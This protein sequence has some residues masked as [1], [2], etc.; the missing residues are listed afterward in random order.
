VRSGN[1]RPERSE[2][3]LPTDQR[4]AVRRP[5]IRAAAAL[6]IASMLALTGC[7]GTTIDNIAVGPGKGWPSAFHDARNSATSTVTGSRHLTASWARPIGG[8]VDA[9]TTVGPDGQL[10]VTTRADVDCVGKPGTTGL[11]FSFQMATGRKRFCYPLGPD[12][13]GAASAV[14]GATNVYVGDNGG[15]YSFNEQGQPRWRTPVAGIPV[16]VQFTGDSRVLSVTQLGQVDVLD[17][18]TGDRAVPTFQVLGDPDFLK[19]PDV[20]RPP[21][22]Q[23]IG[24]CAT[25]GSQCPVANVSAVDQASGRCYVTVWR[26]GSPAASLVALRYADHTIRQEWSADMLTDGSATSPALSADGKTVYVGDNSG[27]LIAV[28]TA[29]GHTKWTQP[30]GF[31]PRGAV[32]VNGD[33][34][35]PGGDEG[36]LL[37]LRDKGDSVEVA[38]ERK[39]LQLRGRPV[40]TAG[41]TGYVVAPIGDALNLVTFD[42]RTGTTVASAELPGVQG[43]TIGTAVGDRGEVVVT[44]RLGELFAFKPER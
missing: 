10:F 20:P 19:S 7:G 36:H 34:L 21:D 26:P 38:W 4:T 28:D 3:D 14:D 16:S 30:L 23:G 43:P 37:A 8:L 44:A 18:Q 15:M 35:I 39:D 13:A 1:R 11:I 9:A 29:D 2:H 40:Q 33:L 6:G 25:G 41:N 24:D 17:R 32:S 42:T 5:A 22:G 31:A 12:V 27:R